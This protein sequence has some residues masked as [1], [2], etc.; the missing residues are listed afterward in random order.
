MQPH[1]AATLPSQRRT[2]AGPDDRGKA[3]DPK[4]TPA[5]FGDPFQL[6]LAAF[7][8]ENIIMLS[9]GTKK[10]EASSRVDW[11]AE[12]LPQ[13]KLFISHVSGSFLQ[14]HPHHPPD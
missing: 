1:F 7:V 11:S 14:D 10:R 3:P 13:V 4:P 2:S 6:Q 8:P 12:E 9:L 5:P